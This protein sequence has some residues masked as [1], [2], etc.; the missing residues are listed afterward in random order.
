[1][2]SLSPPDEDRSVEFLGQ[3]VGDNSDNADAPR[4][5][6]DNDHFPQISL[7]QV[8]P[9]FFEHARH[10]KFTRSIESAE[11]LR[12]LA[13]KGNIVRRKKFKGAQG[14]IHP[15]RGIDPRTDRKAHIFFREIPLI[16]A[17]F[18]KKGVKSW[19]GRFAQNFKSIIGKK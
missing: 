1:M 6:A 11:K 13:G 7:L 15:A 2:R 10:F 17:R 8:L 18:G 14:Y 9:R 16:H 3:L 19:A 12:A 5:I 4:G